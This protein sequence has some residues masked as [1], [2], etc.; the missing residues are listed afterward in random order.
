MRLDPSLAPCPRIKPKQVSDL[1]I[2]T[3]APD[4]LEDKMGEHFEAGV[5][6]DF[7]NTSP[8]AHGII[9]RINKWGYTKLKAS[10]QQRKQECKAYRM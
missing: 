5:G 6:Q 9:P 7:L 4:L 10:A 1:D 2:K 3:K 8:V